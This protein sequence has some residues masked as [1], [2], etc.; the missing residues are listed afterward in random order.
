M[1]YKTFD[2]EQSNSRNSRRH[3][4]ATTGTSVSEDSSSWPPQLA[5]A[6]TSTVN[7]NE[8]YTTYLNEER[9]FVPETNV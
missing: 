8:K 7:E 9:I 2:Q 6:S 5:A 3:S 1:D 4:P